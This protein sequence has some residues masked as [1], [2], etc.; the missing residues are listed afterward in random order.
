VSARKQ[1]LNNAA[2]EDD[3]RPALNYTPLEAELD[4]QAGGIG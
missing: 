3:E 2:R 4:R 1:R